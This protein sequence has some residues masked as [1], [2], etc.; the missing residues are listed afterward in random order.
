M[1][2]DRRHTHRRQHSLAQPL[3]DGQ[4]RPRVEG[5]LR[6][7]KCILFILCMKNMHAEKTGAEDTLETD[8]WQ[9]LIGRPSG[10]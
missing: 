7:I 5:C 8:V 1:H 2:R 6:E 3:T 4:R 9:I 10:V